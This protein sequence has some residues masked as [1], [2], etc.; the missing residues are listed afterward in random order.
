MHMSYNSVREVVLKE[1]WKWQNNGE[2]H[3]VP[4]QETVHMYMYSI[5]VSQEPGTQNLLIPKYG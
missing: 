5:P 4:Y 1:I 3:M 2:L